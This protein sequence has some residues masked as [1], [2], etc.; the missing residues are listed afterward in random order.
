[1]RFALLAL[2]GLGAACSHSLDGTTPQLTMVSPG[3]A[4]NA[5]KS[6]LVSVLGQS[7]AP[8]VDNT[9]DTARLELPQLTLRREQDLD[10]QPATDAIVVPSAT[11]GS[12]TQWVNAT[13]MALTLCPPGVCS[14]AQPPRADLPSLPPGLY[15]VEAQNRAGKSALLASSLAAIPLPAVTSL[16]PSTISRAN[17]TSVVLAGDFLL[18]VDGK[19]PSVAFG[20]L[21]LT[22]TSIDDCRPLPAPAGISLQAC[23]SA[24]V[25]IAA[26][27]LG[28]GPVSITVTNAA[29]V[30]CASEPQTLTITP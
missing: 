6:T 8:L 10:G 18:E 2:A 13:S 25:V 23:R 27:T 5:Q 16:Q 12:D 26:G 19:L 29:P 17:D 4:C 30:D 9:L 24:T 14:T 21:V 22:P 7:F 1:M 3:A 28:A 20:K 11:M 15:G